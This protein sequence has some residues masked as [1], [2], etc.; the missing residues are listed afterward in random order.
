MAST[1]YSLQAWFP[2]TLLHMLLALTKYVYSTKLSEFPSGTYLLCAQF[3]MKNWF[4]CC[5]CAFTRDDSVSFPR[6]WLRSWIG[7]YKKNDSVTR[8]LLKSSLQ[9]SLMDSYPSSLV[10][11]VLLIW[12]YTREKKLE[13]SCKSEAV[14]LQLY[15]RRSQ[16]EA[17]TKSNP[18]EVLNK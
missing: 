11:S 5:S 1:Q 17:E 14:F 16:S 18:F 15:E 2:M 6:V 12:P 4:Q 9:M 7:W 8:A 13:I 3:V 10:I